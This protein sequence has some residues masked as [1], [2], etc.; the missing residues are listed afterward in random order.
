MSNTLHD[1]SDARAMG[2]FLEKNMA[3]VLDLKNKIA[4]MPEGMKVARLAPSLPREIPKFIDTC[5]SFIT[6]AGFSA[7]VKRFEN[8]G[9]LLL[10]LYGQF[11][12]RARLDY[13]TD[14]ET[15]NFDEHEAV[16]RAEKSQHFLLLENALNV[17]RSQE[18]FA[19][20][21]E[22]LSP[23][24]VTPDAAEMLEIARTFRATTEQKFEKV[25]DIHMGAAHLL[26]TETTEASAGTQGQFSVPDHF[27]LKMPI[28]EGG[29]PETVRV[30]L[31]FRR[32]EQRLRVVMLLPTKHAIER[33]AF[34]ALVSEITQATGQPVL[35]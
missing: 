32:V 35:F 21:C 16:F 33:A 28:F 13:H 30:H 7:Y 31:R 23:Y 18:E 8:A 3:P 15:T 9:T 10:G 1:A 5:K 27:V 20:L 6:P 4:L 24:I 22:E 25:T 26:F 2:E 12:V 11:L 19:E 17:K 34:D 29:T 14:A